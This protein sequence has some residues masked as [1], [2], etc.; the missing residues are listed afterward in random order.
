MGIDSSIYQLAGRG[1]KSVAD[2]DNEAAQAKQNKLTEMMSGMK[3]DEYKRGVDEQNQ[4]RSAYAQF[5][6][7][8]T[9][10]TNALYKLGLGKQ[11][12]EYAK[13]QGEL[14]KTKAAAEKDQLSNAHSKLT[15]AAQLLS[16]AKDQASYDASRV[17]AQANGLD[18]SRMPPQFD[19]A[20]VASKLQESQ[21]IAQQLE[22]KWKAMEYTTPN[23]NARLQADTSTANNT[24]TNAT[25]RLN[26]QESNA[27]SRANN[28][29]TVGATIRG[30]NLTDGRARD[31]NNIANDGKVI[32]TETDLR[33][34]FADLPEVK[35]YK[36]AYPSFKAIQDAAKSNNPQADI[37][38]IYGLA[39]LYDPESVVREGEYATIANSQAIPERIKGIAQSL[40]G[41]GKLTPETKRQI[42]EQANNR[43]STFEGEYGKAKDA[44]GGIATGRGARTENVIPK[45]GEPLA[46][47][48]NTPAMPSGFKVIR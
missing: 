22:Q 21:T 42:L 20:F 7:D 18:V 39:K 48:T 19:A 15:L 41:G 30:Q 2:Y 31:A 37:N 29:S 35:R 44:Y 6:A 23:A 34:E 47:S 11:A 5:G 40:V 43:I 14:A 36:A 24:A 16:S 46:P 4:M 1:V 28:Q 9:A 27:T 45:V 32:K 26:N 12:G 38:L 33:K 8:A 3:M 13:S 25:S 17:E 10:N